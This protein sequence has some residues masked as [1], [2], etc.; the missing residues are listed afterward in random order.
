MLESNAFGIQ[1][2]VPIIVADIVDI[3]HY[4][5]SRLFVLLFHC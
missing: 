1:H 2:G 3:R 5:C 4:V